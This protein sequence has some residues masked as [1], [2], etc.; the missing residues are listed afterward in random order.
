M[1]PAECLVKAA[2]NLKVQIRWKRMKYVKLM[3]D[4]KPGVYEVACDH[5]G[6]LFQGIVEL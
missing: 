2:S 5:G 1:G 4:H 3:P 6:G